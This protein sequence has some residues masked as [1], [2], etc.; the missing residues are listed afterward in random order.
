M[1]EESTYN[2]EPV[3]YCTNCL[4]LKIKKVND[5][6]DLDYCDECGGTSIESTHITMWEKLHTARY[7]FNYL[8]KHF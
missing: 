7:G 1:I 6:P 4:S 2:E 8:D 3:H 5:M